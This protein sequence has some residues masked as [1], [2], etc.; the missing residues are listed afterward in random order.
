MATEGLA[1]A[2]GDGGDDDGANALL[3]LSRP[4]MLKPRALVAP[5]P[6]PKPRRGSSGDDGPGDG[7]LSADAAEA[8]AT[9]KREGLTLQ[10]A[11]GASASG[12]MHVSYQG[13]S[14]RARVRWTKVSDADDESDVYLGS[15]GT[16][17]EA[18][19][20]V[21][22]YLAHRCAAL[23]LRD[24][25]SRPRLLTDSARKRRDAANRRTGGAQPNGGGG[26]VG[27][28]HA[29]RPAAGLQG[30]NRL[31]QDG[32]A[33]PCGAAPPPVLPGPAGHVG[34]SLPLGSGLLPIGGFPPALQGAPMQ[35]LHPGAPLAMRGELP[36][37]LAMYAD[38]AAS[39]AAAYAHGFTQGFASPAPF[40]CATPV[41]AVGPGLFPGGAMPAAVLQSQ[42]LG[43]PP[44]P[45]NPAAPP[46]ALGATAPGA[47][48]SYGAF[49]ALASPLAGLSASQSPPYS[50]GGTAPQLPLG[51][52]HPVAPP[53]A[54]P[55]AKPV[56]APAPR[57]AASRP[58][59]PSE[60]LVPPLVPN[61]S[62]GP[63][64]RRA[65]PSAGS[66]PPLPPAA[67][68]LPAQ[69]EPPRRAPKRALPPAAAVAPTSGSPE[70]YRCR[71]SLVAGAQRERSRAAWA[72]PLEPPAL[73]G[74][75]RAADMG[76]PMGGAMHVGAAYWGGMPS[77]LEWYPTGAALL[78]P[79]G[80]GLPSFV[81][82]SAPAA[83]AASSPPPPASLPPPP[84]P[85]FA[86]FAGRV[87]DTSDPAMTQAISGVYP[88][89]AASFFTTP[90]PQA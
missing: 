44:A 55:V 72:P 86:A 31:Y 17:E 60:P 89:A 15:F 63:A 4:A 28:A 34:S 81:H 21:A 68:Q 46:A 49:G 30:D 38:P 71:R 40:A 50:E 66:P 10:L 43:W 37:Y 2:G 27:V 56:A 58:V 33:A 51:F 24:A 65:S 16:A 82:S 25:A 39:D 13:K 59:E 69:P 74:G 75:T 1:V 36:V 5:A 22:R 14:F 48:Y 76:A 47:P 32:C 18:A 67:A 29:P 62:N 77:P 9:A 84:P 20:C 12:Y 80:L 8:I 41:A 79:M 19:L 88:A 90:P 64:A 52:A 53:P 45:T 70:T 35:A 83:P 11:K 61:H 54:A 57:P 7:A 23:G 73:I 26:G 78:A 85:S 87:R 42:G 3:G 6:D